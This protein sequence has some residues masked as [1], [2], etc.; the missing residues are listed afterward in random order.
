[1]EQF[2][3]P[4]ECPGD[5]E[6]QIVCAEEGAEPNLPNSICRRC[7]KLVSEHSSSAQARRIVQ[8]VEGVDE[9]NYTGANRDSATEKSL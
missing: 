8:I 6:W 4:A 5:S 1:L 2:A 7:G 9:A 3:G